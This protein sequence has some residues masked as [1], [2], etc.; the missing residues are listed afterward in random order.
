MSIL[1]KA[2][3]SGL[4]IATLAAGS[5]SLTTTSAEA[6]YRY[7]HR[8][9]GYTYHAPKCFYKYVWRTDYY[10]NSYRKRIRICG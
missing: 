8:H 2:A 10:G 4:A 3:M 9:Y 5:V 1:K 7:G 6:H